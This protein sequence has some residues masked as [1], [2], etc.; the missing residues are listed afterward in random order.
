MTTKEQDTRVQSISEDLCCTQEMATQA[1]PMT[2]FISNGAAASTFV[3]A[4]GSQSTMSMSL[5]QH[6]DFAKSF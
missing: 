3:C 6:T 1:K 4:Q 2:E 5:Q